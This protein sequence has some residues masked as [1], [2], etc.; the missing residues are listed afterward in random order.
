VGGGANKIE[1]LEVKKVSNSAVPDVESDA[2]AA[3]SFV[4]I[5]QL[6]SSETGV[7]PRWG[8][9]IEGRVGSMKAGI[10]GVNI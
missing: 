8:R 2:T 5:R 9:I 1:L 7:A 4:I 6:G 3:G 10:V